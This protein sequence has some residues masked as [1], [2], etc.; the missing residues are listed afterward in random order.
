MSY[1]RMIKRLGS[2][3]NLV[4]GAGSPK[5]P[6][7]YQKI[8]GIMIKDIQKRTHSGKDV[9]FSNFEKYSESYK[10]YKMNAKNKGKS[11]ITYN[12]GVNMSFT[13]NMLNLIKK[14]MISRNAIKLYFGSKRELT[15]AI[16]HITG[17]GVPVRSF[18]GLD[19]KQ[20]KFLL[21]RGIKHVRQEWI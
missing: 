8:G 15:K 4:G 7:Y 3:G 18:W 6:A 2:I 20:L 12:G 5:D 10:E 21:R 1:N 19:E 14:D 11:S 16:K 9:N 13:G 17:D